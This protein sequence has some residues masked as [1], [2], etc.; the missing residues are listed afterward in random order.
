M[1]GEF[2]RAKLRTLMRDGPAE[3]AMATSIKFNM[4]EF[5]VVKFRQMSDISQPYQVSY[6]ISQD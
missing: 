4:L 1:P 5:N 2:G 6:L 3:R